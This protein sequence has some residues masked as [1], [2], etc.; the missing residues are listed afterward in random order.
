M[1]KAIPQQDMYTSNFK[2]YLSLMVVIILCI[3][4]KYTGDFYRRIHPT[5]S[6]QIAHHTPN[7]KHNRQ[8]AR[9][10]GRPSSGS[11]GLIVE[12]NYK[13][14]SAIGQLDSAPQTPNKHTVFVDRLTGAFTMQIDLC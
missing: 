2:V 7:R 12:K 10:V 8:A 13:S 14:R 1:R 5:S 11:N 4:L 9:S 6:L 3:F